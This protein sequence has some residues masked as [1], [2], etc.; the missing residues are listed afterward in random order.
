MANEKKIVKKDLNRVFFRSNTTAASFNF[1]RMHNLGFCFQMIPVIK[2]LYTTKEEQSK[3]LVRHLEFYNTHPYVTAPIVGITIAMEEQRANGADIDDAAINGVKVGMM[4]PLAGVGDPLFWGTLR[5]VMG[6]LGAGFAI[7]G[8]ILGPLVFFFGFN[9]VRLLFRYFSINLGYQKGASFVS[10]LAGNTLKKLTEAASIVGLFIMGS[11]VV[12]W[13][14]MNFPMVIS[15]ITKDD[16][17]VSVTTIQN[18][19]DQLM[20]GLAPLLLTFLCMFLLKKKV[21]PITLIFILFAVGIVAYAL[22][23]LA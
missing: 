12:R 5:P 3:A 6:A 1:E 2:K 21:K 10:D 23:I 11:L 18:I 4:G 9:I 17:S 22:G 7:T 15:R 13:T 19:L 14:S 16:G 20:L 8:S